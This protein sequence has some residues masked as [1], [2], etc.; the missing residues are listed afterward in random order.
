MQGKHA[1]TDKEIKRDD[2]PR[3][4]KSTM[5]LLVGKHNESS[6]YMI[7]TFFVVRNKG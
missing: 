2:E 3:P 5:Q 7:A 1:T 6:V 4:T